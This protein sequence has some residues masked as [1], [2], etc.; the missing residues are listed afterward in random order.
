MA[1]WEAPGIF[2]KGFEVMSRESSF[3]TLPGNVPGLPLGLGEVVS[4]ETIGLGRRGLHV[5]CFSVFTLLYFVFLKIF[6][7]LPPIVAAPRAP[8][9]LGYPLRA[10]VL[11]VELSPP[12]RRQP[13][14]SGHSLDDFV[15][16]FFLRSC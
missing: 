5:P 3:Q 4:E 9:Q 15:V 11:V 6:F 13:Q 10:R 16:S 1:G 12:G 7:S 8:E 14:H 2:S